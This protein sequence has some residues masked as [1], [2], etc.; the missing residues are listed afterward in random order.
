MTP[1]GMGN[2]LATVTYEEANHEHRLV[3]ATI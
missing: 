1:K 2:R 3:I